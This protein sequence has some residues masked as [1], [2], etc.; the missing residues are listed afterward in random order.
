[1]K[2]SIGATGT[3]WID[4]GRVSEELHEFCRRNNI[5]V[6]TAAQRKARQ[7][8][9][10]TKEFKDNIDLEDIGRSK[11]I[12]DNSNIVLLI[13][14]RDEEYLREDMPIHVVKNRDGAKGRILLKKE[15][16][17]SKIANLPDGWAESLGDENEI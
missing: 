1:M 10:S 13:E 15:F 17:C 14:F 2:P 4:V 12:G 7:K 6:I 3:D 9:K 16:E 8:Q 5:P 11:M